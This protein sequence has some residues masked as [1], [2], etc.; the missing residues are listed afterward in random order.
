M[1]TDRAVT[2]C[3]SG[4]RVEK[5]PF[6]ANDPRID[7]LN[8]ALDRA[9]ADASALGYSVF[10][11]GMSTGFDLWA[12]EAVLRARSTLPVQLFCAIPFD[13]QADR[14]SPAWKRHFNHCLLAAD[15]VFALSRDYYT[16]C[17]AARNRFM[18][19]ASSLLICYFDGKPG[20]TAQ[21]VRMASQNGLQIV[22]LA[23]D[24][25]QFF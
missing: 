21:T 4:Y 5:M 20:G 8:T 14:Y 10:F 12:A 6:A 17:Y 9:I 2:C 11:S 16:G 25:I 13:R 1:S 15:R 3:F 22:N 23:D 24:Q 7:T 18:V 19:D